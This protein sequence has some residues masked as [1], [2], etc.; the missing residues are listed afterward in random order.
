M[1]NVNNDIEVSSTLSSKFYSS[2]EI[3]NEVVEN[4]FVTSWHLISDDSYF[5]EENYAFP[6][7]L[8]DKVLPE[9]LFLVKNKNGIECFSNVCTHRGN[10]LI[11]K[12]GKINKTINCNYHG[13]SFDNMGNFLFMPCTERMKNFPTKRDN[14]PKISTSKWNQFIFTSLNPKFSLND[15]TKDVDKR[16][17]W[18]PISD[19]VYR[20]DLSNK[21]I[22]NANWTLYCDNYLEGFHIPFIHKDLNNVLNYEEYSVEC[23]KYSSLQIGYGKDNELC[24]DLPES[25]I[26]YGKKI[27]AYYFWL[28][29]N[30][31]LNF[32]PWGLSI[33][34]IKPLSK[35]QTKVNFYSYVWNEDLLNKGAGADV[36]KVEIEDQEVVTSVQKGVN[37]RLYKSGRFSPDMEQGVHHFHTIIKNFMSNNDE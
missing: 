13:R 19:F 17:G 4:I 25:S 28:F 16:V 27:A 34:I 1:L 24:F 2:K 5:V 12:Y 30:I 35:D 3:F 8:M 21:Y 37:S 6:F 22:I 31:M 10:I 9:P 32:Y 29:P 36:N 14:L 15:L 33:N 23:F 26:D 18:M 20:K 11:K 7:F